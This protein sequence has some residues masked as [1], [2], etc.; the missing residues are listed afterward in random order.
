MLPVD[1]VMTQHGMY[2]TSRGE[3][4]SLESD[5]FGGDQIDF[6]TTTFS[7]QFESVEGITWSDENQNDGQSL[8]DTFGS[9]TDRTL[10]TVYFMGPGESEY[11]GVVNGDYDDEFRQFASDLI[12]LNI[13]DA[14]I[15][16][17]PEFNLNWSPRYPSSGQVYA[18]AFARCVREMM[19]VDGAEFSFLFSPAGNRYGVASDAWPVDSEYW[20]GGVEA[21]LV[22]PSKYDAWGQ[23]PDSEDDISFEELEQLRMESWAVEHREE[24][25]QWVDYVNDYGASG[26]CFPEWGVGGMESWSNPGGGDNPY[27]IDEMRSFME[28]NGVVFQTYWNGSGHGHQVYPPDMNPRSAEAMEEWMAA[29]ITGSD[30]SGTDDGT[31]SG[32]DSEYGGYNQP[33]AGTVNWHKPL[34]ENFGDVEADIKDLAQRVSELE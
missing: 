8:G 5:W 10:N 24:V 9:H 11:E 30:G 28:D 25:Q 21:P 29:D 32:G 17:N 2:V 16:I 6:V 19:A 7:A 15:R 23:Y 13:S 22:G 20:P 31:D 26:L 34:N 18:D 33:E 12:G 3:L 27:F 1:T 14:Y 4:E